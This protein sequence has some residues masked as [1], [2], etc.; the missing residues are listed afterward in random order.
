MQDPS[1]I[2]NLHHRSRQ[3]RILYPLSKARDRAHDL[4]VPS[5]IHFCCTTTG[6][7]NL[8]FK[9]SL[10]T[11]QLLP[12]EWHN[13]MIKEQV[14]FLFLFLLFFFSGHTCGIWKFPGQGRIRAAATGLYH[15]HSNVGSKPHLGSQMMA[16]EA[17]ICDPRPHSLHHIHLSGMP[18][19][20][21]WQ[22]KRGLQSS[23]AR[24]RSRPR[25]RT[26]I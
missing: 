15:S 10:R 21:K 24:Q 2:C 9:Y 8:P 22:I 13:I 20:I 4:M 23:S 7:L 26:G 11:V 5:Q 16:T 25:P 17:I 19:V 12:S 6:T 14:F 18:Q 1:R 3:H